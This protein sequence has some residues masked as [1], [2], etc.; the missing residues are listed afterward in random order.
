LLFFGFFPPA[1]TDR[2]QELSKRL[3]TAETAT[4][5]A[6]KLLWLRRPAVTLI[7]YKKVSW[8]RPD[9]RQAFSRKYTNKI[10]KN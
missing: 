4:R 10:A 1:L 7:I 2:L 9:T 8:S 5:P 3:A 6:T